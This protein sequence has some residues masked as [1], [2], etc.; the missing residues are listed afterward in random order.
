[1]FAKWTRGLALS[2]LLA[3]P[4]LAH[5][6]KVGD[7]SIAHP[8]IPQ[9]ASRAMVAGGFFAAHNAGTEADRLIGIEAAF[10]ARAEVHVTDHGADGSARMRHVEAIEIPAGETIA[11]ERGGYHVMFMGLKHGLEAGVKLPATLIFEKAGRLE[12]EFHV[13]AQKS[14]AK[15]GH[16]HH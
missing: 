3:A 10:A 7:L 13:E 8:A 11:F 5:D 6:Y 12:V 4:A 16:A 14:P 1:M 15:G 9:P 2:L